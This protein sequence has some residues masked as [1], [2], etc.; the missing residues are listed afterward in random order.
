MF[1]T[2]HRTTAPN[3]PQKITVHEHRA[4]TD[5]SVKLLEE[6]K[7]EAEKNIIDSFKFN[8]NKVNGVVIRSHLSVYE[9]GQKLYIKFTL[10]GKEYYIQEMFKNTE[11]NEMTK[12]D[13]YNKLCKVLAAR[14]AAELVIK[15][16]QDDEINVI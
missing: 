13:F 6:F 10:N 5:E 12:V 1:D 7:K 4:P 16:I 11:L 3:Y 2:Y 14:I 8:D 15:T 9:P